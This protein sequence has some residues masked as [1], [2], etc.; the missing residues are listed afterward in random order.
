[1]ERGVDAELERMPAAERQ[2]SDDAAA[3]HPRVQHACGRRRAEDF[4][5]RAMLVAVRVR[6]E[7]ALRARL[8]V[9]PTAGPAAARRP[10]GDEPPTFCSSAAE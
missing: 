7:R 2:L 8:R 4:L 5:V 6:D 10:C 9:E 1:M 3:R